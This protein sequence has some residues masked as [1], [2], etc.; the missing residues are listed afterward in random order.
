[1][2]SGTFP[3]FSERRL[4][5][6]AGSFYPAERRELESEVRRLLS[7]E[8]A[9]RIEGRPK[10]LIVPHAGYGYSGA[11]AA[12]AYRLLEGES[13]DTVVLLGPSHQSHFRGASAGRHSSYVT[14]LGEL[15]VDQEIVSR[16][17][18]AER[19]ISFRPEAHET[20]HSLEVQLPFVQMTLGT[21]KIV[22]ILTGD[23]AFDTC[24]RLAAALHREIG[25][26]RALTI[27]STDL[28]HY[29]TYEDA[30]RI[31]ERTLSAITGG[32]PSK[33]HEL[34]Q[35]GP[36]ELCGASAVTTLLLLSKLA[37][38]RPP[39]LLAAAN[40]G[41]VTGDRSRV[42]GYAAFALPAAA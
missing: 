11:V 32:D 10:G 5:A 33:F 3:Q 20:E 14:P 42:V 29:H 21:P 26:R 27:A 28:S 13:F 16:L 6:V 31:D 37:G 1:M 38:G 7:A 41:D 8:P 39:V 18:S 4:P 2:A 24:Q 12:A 17:I 9:F 15:A 30:K 19:C 34:A 40:S 25:G 23:V 35:L 36:C 22:P